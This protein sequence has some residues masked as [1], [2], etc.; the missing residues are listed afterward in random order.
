[1]LEDAAR[2]IQECYLALSSI[3]DLGTSGS[4]RSDRSGLVCVGRVQR[5]ERPAGTGRLAASPVS[6]PLAGL[7][8]PNVA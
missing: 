6:E 1:M 4:V 7:K 2:E 5:S 3:G 8:L